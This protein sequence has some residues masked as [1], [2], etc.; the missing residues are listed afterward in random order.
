MTTW[1]FTQMLIGQVIN[2]I[3]RASLAVFL[4]STDVQYHGQ[5]RSQRQY[6]RRA[7]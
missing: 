1:L 7:V 2:P 4:C 6:Q 5:A 3:E